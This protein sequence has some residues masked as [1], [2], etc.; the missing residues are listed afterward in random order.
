VAVLMVLFFGFFCLY[1]YIL[2]FVHSLP[3]G[4]YFKSRFSGLYGW[5]FF[6]FIHC[7][8]LRACCLPSG[9]DFS[10]CS[11]VFALWLLPCCIPLWG[12]FSAMK[13]PGA[14]SKKKKK[15]HYK[16]KRIEKDNEKLEIEV[17]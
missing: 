8:G 9:S 3:F 13:D 6:N 11:P 16:V 15:I 10:F 2:F 1:L 7:I 14:C 17:I 5:S 4:S 12:F